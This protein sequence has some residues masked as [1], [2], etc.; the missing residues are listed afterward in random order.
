MN[1]IDRLQAI[2]IQL[3]GKRIVKAQEIAERFGISLRTVYRDIRSLEEAGVPIAAE[4][5]V[6]YSLM[7]HYQLPPVSFT[8]HEASALLFGEKL[9]E[10]MSDEAVRQNFQSAIFKIKAI[11]RP[12]EKEHLELLHNRI[13]VVNHHQSAHH[14]GHL[15]LTEIQHAMTSKKVVEI[16]YQS[17]NSEEPEIRRV[18]PIGLCNYGSRWHMLA[19]CRLRGDYRDF[20]LDRIQTLH[21]LDESFCGS[22][23]PT[24]DELL[25][26]MIHPKEQ[27]NIILTIKEERRKFM[28]DSRH[29]YGFLHEEKLE[30]DNHRLFFFNND[31]NGFA[32]WLLATGCMAVIEAPAELKNIVAQYVGK[33]A[34]HYL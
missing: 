16:H 23:H 29:Y 33:S 8:H 15:H 21:L 19:W 6:G 34:K 24:M 10:Q 31:L 27:H 17:R 13:A 28:M 26:R 11:L 9:V 18:E 3:Q 12:E 20:R 30:G 4:A 14:Q 1:R 32:V 25:Q 22:K 5:G 2:L 7:S